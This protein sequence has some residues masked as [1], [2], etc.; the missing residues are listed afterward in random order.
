MVARLGRHDLAERY[1]AGAATAEP[2]SDR[3]ARNLAMLRDTHPVLAALP[4][5]PSPLAK[6]EALRP[7]PVKQGVHLVRVSRGEVH[8]GGSSPVDTRAAPLVKLAAKERSAV[9]TVIGPRR[10][11][12]AYPVI[13]KLDQLPGLAQAR[14]ERRPLA[15]TLMSSAQIAAFRLPLA[16][17]AQKPEWPFKTGASPIQIDLRR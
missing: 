3:Y 1:F 10:A 16:K 15:M 8:I 9:I 7:A 11:R 4:D 13:V 5:Q 12:A 6:E 17:A 14:A 2:G